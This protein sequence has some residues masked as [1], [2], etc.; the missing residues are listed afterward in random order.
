MARKVKDARAA[1]DARQKKIAIVGAVLL[2]AVLAFQGPKTMK[3]LKGAEA[4]TAAPAVPAASTPPTGAPV[5]LEPP[6]LTG[7]SAAPTGDVAPALATTGGA[8]AGQLVSFGRFESKDPFRPQVDPTQLTDGANPAQKASE[9]PADAPPGGSGSTPSLT[10]TPQPNAP[11]ARPT[12]AVISVN[13]VPEVVAVKAEFPAAEPTFELVALTAKTAKIA[14]AGG[15]YA[16]GAPTVTLKR[17]QKLTLMNTSDGRR[18]E[19][20]WLPDSAAPTAA[21]A[22]PAAAPAV[23]PTGS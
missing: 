23:P 1:K 4:S 12:S 6:S 22:A 14:V 21:P 5:S 11:A 13:G 15:S 16:S 3:M 7:G 19:L 20:Q 8:T 2:V 9:A 18:Y 10:A 17:G